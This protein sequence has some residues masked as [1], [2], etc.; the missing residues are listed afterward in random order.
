ME[1]GQGF[2]NDLFN[3]RVGRVGQPCGGNGVLVGQDLVTMRGGFQYFIDPAVVLG[4]VVTLLILLIFHNEYLLCQRITIWFARVSAVSWPFRAAT[5]A[6]PKDTAQPAEVPVI[7]LPSRTQ[8]APGT[9]LAL[10]I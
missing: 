8:A 3:F 5:S 7:S 2:L 4:K 6:R 10:P 1:L 9:I